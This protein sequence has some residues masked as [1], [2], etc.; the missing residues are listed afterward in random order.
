VDDHVFVERRSAPSHGGYDKCDVVVVFG[1][2][3]DAVPLNP[4]ATRYDLVGPL[5]SSGSYPQRT[6][7]DTIVDEV[8]FYAGLRRPGQVTDRQYEDLLV[9]LVG[10]RGGER[11]AMRNRIAELLDVPG[12][13][14]AYER[15]R[16]GPLAG[17]RG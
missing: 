7:A 1:H 4:Y 2:G 12:L 8:L 14:E 13:A 16:I 10:E 15:E 9:G 5:A 6:V 11:R 3:T 17:G